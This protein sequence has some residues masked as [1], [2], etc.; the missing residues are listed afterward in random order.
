MKSVSTARIPRG[1]AAKCNG[2]YKAQPALPSHPS[3]FR[4]CCPVPSWAR[5]E[6]AK[7][8]PLR[9]QGTTVISQTQK[10][11]QYNCTYT[12]CLDIK[13]TETKRGMGWWLL[14][15]REGWELLFRDSSVPVWDY[16]RVLEMGGGDSHNR[17]NVF[18]L[19][20]VSPNP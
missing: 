11:K 20:G 5:Q 17:V 3:L 4:M 10:A 19:A 16:T 15:W 6:K 18:I 1:I 13:L 12:M 2:L 9:S 14:S 7:E 8:E